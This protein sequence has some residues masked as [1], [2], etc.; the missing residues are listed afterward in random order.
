VLLNEAKLDEPCE[1]ELALEGVAL[2]NAALEMDVVER[3]SFVI[4]DVLLNTF[5]E[6]IV[7]LL[8]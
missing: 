4:G 7:A 3:N 8:P 2:V 5:S 1:C 6:Y